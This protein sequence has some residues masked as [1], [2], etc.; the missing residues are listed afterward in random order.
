MQS[1]EATATLAD[2]PRTWV[3][4]T[5]FEAGTFSQQLDQR[6]NVGGAITTAHTAAWAATTLGYYGQTSFDHDLAGGRGPQQSRRRR[7]Q[8]CHISVIRRVASGQHQLCG[9]SKVTRKSDRRSLCA[10]HRLASIERSKQK[11]VGASRYFDGI[12]A[13][14]EVHQFDPTLSAF[15]NLRDRSTHCTED[16]DD[17]V[18]P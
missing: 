17:E 18:I 2:G 1:F 12:G 8:S 5:R 15:E 6:Q 3:V 4:G 16:D 13:F 9:L 14:H 11:S 10:K 7:P